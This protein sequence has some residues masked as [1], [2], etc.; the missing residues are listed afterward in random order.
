M[1]SKLYSYIPQQF[2]EKEEIY[3]R[4]NNAGYMQGVI[5]EREENDEMM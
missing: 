4:D 2:I 5:V 1:Q 3:L